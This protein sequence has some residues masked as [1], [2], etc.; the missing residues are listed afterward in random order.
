V[1]LAELRPLP[2]PRCGRGHDLL[3]LLDAATGALP[4]GRIVESACPACAAP[5]HLELGEGTAAIGGLAAERPSL[6]RSERRVAQPGLSVRG[7]PEGL[8]VRLLHRRWF[9]AFRRPPAAG[10]APAPGS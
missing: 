7:G 10:R 6:L 9:V 2:C 8:V 1:S 3:V 5:L 4:G